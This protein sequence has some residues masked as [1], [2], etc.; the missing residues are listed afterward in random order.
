MQGVNR[1]SPG[2]R[3]VPGITV[4]PLSFLNLGMVRSS[5]APVGVFTIIMSSRSS[6]LWT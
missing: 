5:M 4:S 1:V 3:K 6:R 2:E